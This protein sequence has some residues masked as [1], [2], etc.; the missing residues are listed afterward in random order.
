MKIWF[1]KTL[2]FT[3][4]IPE[5]FSV[6]VVY[7]YD[8]GNDSKMCHQSNYWDHVAAQDKS[9]LTTSGPFQILKNEQNN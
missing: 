5:T 1:P 8:G 4:G 9:W 6:K 2:I 3:Q 7:C